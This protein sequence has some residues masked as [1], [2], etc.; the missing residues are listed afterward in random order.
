MIHS[1]AW[2][3]GHGNFRLVLVGLFAG[4]DLNTQAVPRR[5]QRA[6]GV[7]V[8]RA[9]RVVGLVEIKFHGAVFRRIGLNEARGRIG[10]LTAGQ[11]A[12]NDKQ[13]SVA[14]GFGLKPI[15]LPMQG[16]NHVSGERN[17]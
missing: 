1:P 6:R 11:I 15:F 2:I 16:K 5:R 3:I 7:G 17:F 8:V 9:R 14:I 13:P 4:W 10:F 12:K